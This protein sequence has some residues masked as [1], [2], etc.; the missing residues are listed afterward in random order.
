MK[1]MTVVN[2]LLEGLPAGELAE[3]HRHCEPV[4]LVFGD[5]LIESGQP[6][7]HV[8]FPLTGF[9]SLLM[10][11]DGHRPME[12]GMIGNE[13]MLGVTLILGIDHA[14]LSGVV[15]GSGSALRMSASHF[16]YAILTS[17]TWLSTLNRYLY[18]LSAQVALGGPCS[19]FHEVQPR[20]ARWLLMT[21]DRAHADHFH[22]THLFLAE[23]LG[24]QRSAITIA[25]GA[26]QERGIISYARGEI[27]V[28]S[29]KKLEAASCECYR[30]SV[31]DYERLF[32]RVDINGTKKRGLSAPGET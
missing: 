29:R 2:R 23:M 15:Q 32:D 4:E 9:I 20:L 24:V 17:P 18:V 10:A 1:S 22:L 7:S 11:V 8:Y 14:P 12:L 27:Q 13:G 26:L 25:A 6:C 30:V 5:S 16:R 3:I 31:Q 21:H 28:L 19:H